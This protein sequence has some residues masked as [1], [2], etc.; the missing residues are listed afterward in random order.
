MGT[1]GV[2]ACVGTADYFRVPCVAF[3]TNQM[4]INTC[5]RASQ[6]FEEKTLG[7]VIGGVCVFLGVI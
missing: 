6:S 2:T 5:N 7:R 1:A 4:V 3:S